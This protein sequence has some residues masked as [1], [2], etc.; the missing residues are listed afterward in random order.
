MRPLTRALLALALAIALTACSKPAAP[1]AAQPTPAQQPAA[2]QQS[3][4]VQQSAAAAASSASAP[5]VPQG[6]RRYAV[7][8]AESTAAYIA[9]EKFVERPLPNEAVGTTREI[10]GE[11]I[12]DPNG[13]FLPSQVTVDLRTLQ[14]DSGRRDNALRTRWLESNQYPLAEFRIRGVEGPA[15]RWVEGQPA[16]FRLAGI[17]QVHGTEKPVI[18]DAT[19]TRSGE[20]L[21]VEATLA[22]KMSDFGIRVPDIA[23]LLKAEDD[24]K[25]QVKLVARHQP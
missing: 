6:A 25:L 14:S 13:Q 2:A 3:A 12:L 15:P 20:T 1:P 17:L 11:L 5:T 10:R 4:A 19:A 7:V 9:R 22:L 23:G 16:A 18:W 24:L 8:G 21:Q